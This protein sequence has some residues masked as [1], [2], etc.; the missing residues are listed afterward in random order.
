M[1]CG[2]FIGDGAVCLGVMMMVIVFVVVTLLRLGPFVMAGSFL[3][4]PGTVLFH[5]Q[6]PVLGAPDTVSIA[7]GIMVVVEKWL[8]DDLCNVQF[9]RLLRGQSNVDGIRRGRMA[10]EIEK[11]ELHTVD[12]LHQGSIWTGG[13]VFDVH[14]VLQ[15]QMLRILTGHVLVS[16]C[17]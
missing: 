11:L 1:C 16:G 5:N 10:G 9:A 15:E 8:D 2:L 4:A 3:L 17:R 13:H 7:V 6:V 14:R 12:V